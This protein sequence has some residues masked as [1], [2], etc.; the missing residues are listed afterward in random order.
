MKL[1]NNTR[2]LLVILIL[3]LGLLCTIIGFGLLHASEQNLKNLLPISLVY[4]KIEKEAGEYLYKNATEKACS[5]S[6]LIYTTRINLLK[7]HMVDKLSQISPK[8][9]YINYAYNINTFR[10]RNI[11]PQYVCAIMWHESRFQPD[12]MNK[13][14]GV[15]GLTQI[16]P[17]WHTKRAEA[18]GVTDL[19]DPY[20]NIM[21]CFD[22]L[23]ELT[24]SHD[25]SYALNFFAGGYPYANRYKNSTSPFIN[26]LNDIIAE[27]DFESMVI[28]YLHFFVEEGL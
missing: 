12:V 15:V 18:L 23:N 19:R 21:V 5:F 14:T 10:Y 7:E 16:N 24:E 9:L 2:K 17:K 6:S 25:F 13:K 11:D 20:G 4:E 22:I 3:M 1:T 27:E 8:E 28:P 26:Q